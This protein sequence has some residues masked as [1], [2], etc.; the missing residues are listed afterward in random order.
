MYVCIGIAARVIMKTVLTAY[1]MLKHN[2]IVLTT[3]SMFKHNKTVLTA[4]S[5]FKHNKNNTLFE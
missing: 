5:M 3:Y 1:S 4:Y 2:K